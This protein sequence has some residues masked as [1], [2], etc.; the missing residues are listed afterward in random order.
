M[1]SDI[2]VPLWRR[3]G[4]SGRTPLVAVVIAVLAL[5]ATVVIYA[6]ARAPPVEEWPACPPDAA[7]PW[8][9]PEALQELTADP[10]DLPTMVMFVAG[11]GHNDGMGAESTAACEYRAIREGMEAATAARMYV[12]DCEL[13]SDE[14]VDTFG[15]S[16]DSQLPLLWVSRR[17]GGTVPAVFPAVSKTGFRYTAALFRSYLWT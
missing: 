6:R 17:R 3:L 12:L 2:R 16:R 10:L 9:E 1:P 14:C 4:F 11:A 5:V 15:L 7:V 8:I 13:A